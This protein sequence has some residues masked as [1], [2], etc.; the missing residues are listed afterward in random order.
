MAVNILIK[1]SRIFDGKEGGGGGGG[2]EVISQMA[3]MVF[4]VLPPG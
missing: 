3:K 2:G 1:L 4:I